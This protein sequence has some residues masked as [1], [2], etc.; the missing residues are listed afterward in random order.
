MFPSRTRSIVVH[1][2]R[3]LLTVLL[4]HAD[5]RAP[6][7]VSVQLSATPA[8][9][10]AVD[11]QATAGIEPETPVLTHF[12]LPDVGGS[13]SAVFGVELGTPAGSGHARFVSHPDGD[14]TLSEVDDLA[15]VV[16]V[17][18]PPWTLTDVVAY[19]RA[20]DELDMTIVDAEPPEESIPE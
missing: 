10:F 14:P 18:T 12:T 3:D 4:E 7:D 1:V 20:G 5:D 15:A 17:A 13:I 2:T 6:D 8:D 16:L 19:D 9:E 11:L